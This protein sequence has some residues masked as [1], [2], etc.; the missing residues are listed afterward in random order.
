MTVSDDTLIQ[1]IVAACGVASVVPPADAQGRTLSPFGATLGASPILRPADTAQ[2]ATM[3]RLLHEAGRTLVP[4]GGA[5]GLAGG[6]QPSGAAGEWHLSTERMRAIELLDPMSRIAV[7]QAGVVL[8]TMQD[9]AAREDL[10]FPVDLG[11]RGS[12]TI[13]GLIATNAGGERV[14][15]F[16]MM[17]E[18]VLGLEVVLADG[19]V[20]DLM[21]QVVKN[22][23]G[24]DLKQLFIG[25]EGTLGIVTRA[26]LRLR[27]ALPR[28]EAAFLAVEDLAALPRLLSRV[29]SA[30]GGSLSAFELMWPSF[31][32]LMTEQH[33]VEPARHR[34][35]VAAGAAA[36]VLIELEDGGEA[37]E[38]ER[39]LT[40]LDQLVEEGLL[41]DAAVARSGADQEAFW[42]IRNDI[43]HL[44][45]LLQPL[46]AFD[47]SVPIAHMV[48][49][50][51]E[52]CD[53]VS[54]RW[55]AA[56]PVVFGHVADNNLHVVV[57]GMEPSEKSA[58]EA[59]VYAGVHRR[60]GS[61]S[62]EHG[63]GLDKRAALRDSRPP[64]V[65]ALMAALKKMLD[66][67]GLLNPGKVI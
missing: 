38:D 54:A 17:R 9:A 20:L 67:T 58:L 50:V 12:A 7:V 53:A 11:A 13:G 57:G 27:P 25:S 66:P 29:E 43:E 24:Y 19:S 10:L 32:A 59:I 28:H 56:R 64:E 34:S 52:L 62:A 21:D 14:L 45:R 3:V 15:R 44:I 23:A 4:L 42:A 8:Q 16:G 63:I 1:R 26:V 61:I 36:Y 65:M 40:L 33:G 39:L 18:Q 49:Y 6:V 31:H 37:A 5:T 47:V 48:D 2:V 30:L 60:R 51:D 41:R 35:P 22:N 46:H 55:P